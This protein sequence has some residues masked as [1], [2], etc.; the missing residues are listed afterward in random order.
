MRKTKIIA[1][2]GILLMLISLLNF[3]YSF[4]TAS[5]AYAS[6][7]HFACS[8]LAIGFNCKGDL[9]RAQ[10]GDCSYPG[11]FYSSSSNPQK[12]VFYMPLNKCDA[13]GK[14]FS[15]VVDVV[16]ARILCLFVFVVGLLLSL[17]SF[18]RYR[19]INLIS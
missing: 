4:K 2:L 10:G 7:D 17:I 16:T 11:S 15:P 6:N 5:Q 12:S 19:K 18:F 3:G 8:K 1:I 14:V 9:G 13:P